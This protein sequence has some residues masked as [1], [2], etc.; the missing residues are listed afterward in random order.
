MSQRY[1]GGFITASYNGLL[2][3]DAPTIGTATPGGAS[4]S[5][6]FTAPSNVGG[7]AITGYTAIS[8]PGGFIG[9]GT[10]SPITVSGLTNGTAYTFK[11]F[12]TNAY[13]PSAF[14]AASNSAT[15]VA[16]WMGLLGDTTSDVPY[17]V[18]VDSASNVYLGGGS[19]ISSVNQW[20]IAKYNLSGVLQWQKSINS[21]S[22]TASSILSLAIDSSNN[23]YAFGGIG[24][25]VASNALQ[26]IK[27]DTSGTILWQRNLVTAF[28]NLGGIRL[29]GSNNVYICGG[30]STSETEIAKYDSSGAIQWQRKLNATI[31][32]C[33]GVDGSANVYVAGYNNT[34]GPTYNYFIAKYD[35]SGTLQWSRQLG[36]GGTNI[37]N[38]M[39]VDSS[40]N[41]YVNGYKDAA[42]ADYLIAKYNTS[43]TIQWQVK[44]DGTQANYGTSVAVDSAGNVYVNGQINVSSVS[45]FGMAKYNSSG[46]LQWQRKI[47]NGSAAF[48]GYGIALDS[49]DTMYVCGV[50]GVGSGSNDFMFA[51]LPNDGSLTGTYTVGGASITYSTASSTSTV[52][53]HTDSA[54]GL[55]SSTTTK[56]DAATTRSASTS[57]LVSNTTTL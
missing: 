48:T 11:V 40:G 50:A 6:A 41:V 12:A 28:N 24:D 29:D 56:T 52:A 17:A 44:L 54:G 13:G 7:G 51:K 35:T 55:S 9:T 26:I 2:V 37:C 8:S 4:A 14:S 34:S 22:G 53:T 15:P 39:A 21:A 47:G 46:T 49:S 20:Q 36:D 16:Y 5:V 57:T 1:Q 42:S 38:G 33:I 18:A 32:T 3:P 10:A 23:I 43:G 31:P 25:D 45:Y 19:N 30:G 27:L